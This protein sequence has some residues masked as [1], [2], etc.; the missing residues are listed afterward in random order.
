MESVTFTIVTPVYNRKDCIGRCIESVV[1]QNYNDI[2]YWIVDDGS[3]DGTT[4]VIERYAQQYSYIK[5]HK[6]NRN[7]GVNAAR[8]YGIQHSSNDFV[9]FLDSDDYLISE[10]LRTIQQTILT[11]PEYRHYLFA[12]NDRITYYN[13]H[14]FLKEQKTEV[15]FAD[16]LSGTVT[17]DFMHVME[18]SLV[19]CFPFN[20]YLR[21]YEELQFLSIF[22][23]GKKQFFLN[24]ILVNRER[25]RSDSVTKEY[26]LKN[27]ESI[28]KQYIFLKEKLS[29][30]ENDYKQ[31]QNQNILSNLIKRIFILG[32]ALGKYKENRLIKHKAN[33]MNI[34][35]P[36]IFRMIEQFRLGFLLR[37]T[38]FA[39]SFIKNLV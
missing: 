30:F 8:N 35:F 37:N 36:F 21:T 23:A 33:N 38:I 31:L 1:N 6:F 28:L 19:K 29:L 39:Y 10:A 11:Y 13:Q 5:H 14:P 26:H 17:G 16:F 27:K 32:L 18:A 34:Q 25:N 4:Q 22:K 2:E 15:S 24:E 7:R 12:Q 20:E 9:I 3:T